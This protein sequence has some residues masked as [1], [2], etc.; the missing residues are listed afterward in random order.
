[1]L[2]DLEAVDE[3][4]VAGIDVLDSERRAV[5]GLTRCYLDL[6]R[7][8]LAVQTGSRYASLAATADAAAP[9]LAEAYDAIGEPARAVEIL[10]KAVARR[11]DDVDLLTRLGQA[12]TQAGDAK[13]GETILRR[14]VESNGAPAARV[15]LGRL[16]AASSRW[17][18]A[19]EQFRDA[20][21]VIPSLGDAAFGLSEIEHARGNADSAIHVLVD[22]LEIDPYNL[23]GL[24]RLGDTLW[25][26]G[27]QAEAAVAYR[28]VLNFDP[29]HTEALEGL[30]R[31]TPV[32]VA[33]SSG[34][35][36]G[37][38]DELWMT[39]V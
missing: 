8:E 31:L 4:S 37:E 2:A 22:F 18:E 23:N 17:A 15:A 5:A 34:R 27:R 21:A 39:Q 26:S 20:L 28:R 10:A 29:A 6:D 19:E 30:E 38:D 1:V 14:A 7:P 12:H 9:L 16:M 13:T 35:G 25:L 24:V 33:I 32:E 11:P 3:V 36:R